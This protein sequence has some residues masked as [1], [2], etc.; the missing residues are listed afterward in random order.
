MRTRFALPVVLSLLAVPGTAADVFAQSTIETP[1]ETRVDRVTVFTFGARITRLGTVRVPAG[2][3]VLVFSGL[4][5]ELDPASLRVT[6]DGP[7]TIQSV[8]SRVKYGDADSLNAPDEVLTLRRRLDDLN[9]EQ[10]LLDVAIESIDAEQQY[11][12]T[13][14]ANPSDSERPLAELVGIADF[15]RDRMPEI[16]TRK[17]NAGRKS[18]ELREEAERIRKQLREYASSSRTPDVAEAIVT[19]S[20]DT[21]TEVAF[22]LTYTVSSASWRTHYDVRSPSID[23]PITLV[24]FA[25]IA[26]NSGEDWN[27]VSVT[28]STGDL[29]RSNELP[30]LET[31]WLPNRASRF[32]TSQFRPSP[33]SVRTGAPVDDT[34]RVLGTVWDKQSG[35]PIPGANIVVVGTNERTV[36]DA[37]GSYLIRGQ[38]LAQ[39]NI[40]VSFIGYQSVM[41]S[42]TSN[43]IDFYLDESAMELNE[44]VIE[45]EPDPFDNIIFRGGRGEEARYVV[46]GRGVASVSLDVSRS[47]R[48]TVTEYTIGPRISIPTDAKKRTFEIRQIEAPADFDYVTVPKEVPS[49]FLTARIPNWSQYDLEPG[50]MALYVD[51]VFVGSAALDPTNTADTLSIGLGEDPSV[52]IKRERRDD[53]SKRNFFG[54]K[55]ER[56]L[57]FRI[58]IRNNREE[59]I[60]LT[61][62]DQ[63]PISTDK[64]VTVD[65]G[66]LSGGMLNKETGE[67]KWKVALDPGET[68]TIEFDYSARYPKGLALVLD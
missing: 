52:S 20:S 42:I 5:K 26:Q 6:P 24:H 41:T 50:S 15:V 22:D 56:R 67:I 48:R 33:T 11:V 61:I 47:E 12:A 63:I 10:E 36:T 68:H 27:D 29:H 40:Q 3:Q 44:I 34:D 37:D 57:G 30:E 4:P 55:E 13:L 53:F 14:S 9:D 19:V 23:E 17:L 60:A 8:T 66:D 51:E 32:S 31:L 16:K 49:A 59:A 2:T 18:R 1:V 54:S 21:S 38:S 25:D 39:R 45:A 43:V 58:T 46:D 7:V 35:E 28:I 64:S 62:R 65:A